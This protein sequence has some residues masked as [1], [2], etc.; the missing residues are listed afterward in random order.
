M[1][2]KKQT[3]RSTF[4]NLYVT[5][6]VLAV[7]L[8]VTVGSVL[9]GRA[10]EG[11]INVSQAIQNA[12]ATAQQSAAEGEAAP[13]P[14]RDTRST[15][16]NGG[17]VGLGDVEEPDTNQQAGDDAAS[18]EQETDTASTTDESDPEASDD[19]AETDEP[20]DDASGEESASS[21]E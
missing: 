8:I 10:D 13:E 21:S 5:G 19:T 9:L 14:V 11:T 7:G 6:G 12:N 15:E 20:T 3:K 17:L 18:T 1:P 4:N 16:K 2:A